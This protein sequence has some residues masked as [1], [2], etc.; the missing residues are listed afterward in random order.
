MLYKRTFPARLGRKYCSTQI[1]QIV[2][3]PAKL[4]NFRK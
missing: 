2:D 1:A 3:F 4:A